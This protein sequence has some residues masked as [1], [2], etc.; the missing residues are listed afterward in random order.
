ME[1][2]QIGEISSSAL[3]QSWVREDGGEFLFGRLGVG[4]D[5]VP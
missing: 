5:S 4:C 3:E 2:T 1:E